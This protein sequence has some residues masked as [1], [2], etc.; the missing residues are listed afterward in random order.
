VGE[1]ASESSEP[2]DA[3]E[4]QELDSWWLRDLYVQA[5]AAGVTDEEY[6]RLTLTKVIA[7]IEAEKHRR[8]WHAKPVITA[9]LPH[10]DKKALRSIASGGGG[11]SDSVASRALAKMLE[12]YMPASARRPSSRSQRPKAIPEL[13]AVAARGV[14]LAFQRGLLTDVLWAS[15]SQWY[16]RIAETAKRGLSSEDR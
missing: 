7:R 4:P 12:E 5:L 16:P 3:E 14:V 9:M 1:P 13:P 8:Y 10:L 2:G 15:I 6:S 11:K